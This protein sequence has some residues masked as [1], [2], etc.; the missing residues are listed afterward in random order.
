MSLALG[1]CIFAM[2]LVKQGYAGIV[3]NARCFD[4]MAADGWQGFH[5]VHWMGAVTAGPPLNDSAWFDR[6]GFRWRSRQAKST[7]SKGSRKRSL[8][9]TGDRPFR[10]AIWSMEV[11]PSLSSELKTTPAT[12]PIHPYSCVEK[13][14]TTW[15]MR[16]CRYVCADSAV[17]GRIGRKSILSITYYLVACCGMP[18]GKSRTRITPMIIFECDGDWWEPDLN[19]PRVL[20]TV[21]HNIIWSRRCIA[22]GVFDLGMYSYLLWADYECPDDCAVSHICWYRKERLHASLSTETVMTAVS[23]IKHIVVCGI[24]TD[25][26]FGIP[27]YSRLNEASSGPRIASYI[28]FWFYTHIRV[29]A[30]AAAYNPEFS[31]SERYDVMSSAD[32]CSTWTRHSSS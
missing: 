6:R 12:E 16:K 22:I 5:W 21:I 8:Q 27:S 1:L 14:D 7:S 17:S 2:G 23:I 19:F 10:Y 4:L 31:S 20:E 18:F 30:C 9:T 3:I 15:P 11:R 26:I 32:G 28:T 24:L 25:S 13:K 29:V